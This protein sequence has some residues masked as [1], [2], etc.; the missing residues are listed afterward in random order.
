MTNSIFVH[1][2]TKFNRDAPFLLE[3]WNEG[4][5]SLSK[6]GEKVGFEVYF[7]RYPF[8]D[9]KDKQLRR[10]WVYDGK[11]KKTKNKKVDLLYFRGQNAEVPKIGQ[12][13]EEQVNLPI[14]N[15]LELEYVCDDKLL[16]HNIFPNLVP[17]TFL[18]NDSYTVQRVL[19]YIPSDYIV[20]KPRYGSFGRGVVILH[21]KDF[22]NGVSKDMVI[23]EFVNTSEGILNVKK[24]H[25][26]RT[27]I[28]D[29]KI[30]HCYLRI[31]KKGSLIC[32]TAAGGKKIFIDPEDIPSRVIRKIKAIDAKFKHYGPRIYSID[33]IQDQDKKI[34]LL[35]L[36]SKPGTF[37]YDNSKRIR[38]RFYRNTF[39]AMEKML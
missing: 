18:V 6:L 37:Y 30:D 11:W 13:I 8:Y 14:I 4:F 27:I 1:C 24:V 10:A 19:N 38:E 28:V 33:L 16:T 22:V 12:Q 39:K 20:L 23:Q 29:G 7:S 9:R 5:A 21:K 36:N 3:R 25:D 34:R 26:F 32:N 15:N 35:E 31:P 17:K 2:S